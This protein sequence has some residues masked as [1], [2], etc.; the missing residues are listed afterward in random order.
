MT[1]IDDSALETFDYENST[2]QAL[3]NFAYTDALSP[4]DQ[5]NLSG[6]KFWAKLP[7]RARIAVYV[8]NLNYQ[9]G[10][11]GF[12]QWAGNRFSLCADE[13]VSFLVKLPKAGPAV[14]KMISIV[15]DREAKNR[16]YWHLYR[17]VDLNDEY[18]KRRYAFLHEVEAVLNLCSTD[19]ELA[20]WIKR[21]R[22]N[23][24]KIVTKVEID[25]V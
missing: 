24:V 4:E 11:G 22:D 12:G 3:M 17:G 18:V 8:G 23:K 7:L 6:P 25:F 19:Q 10:N 5:R 15:L 20:N 9:V 16:V 21:A 14:A 2:I 1:Q 13:L